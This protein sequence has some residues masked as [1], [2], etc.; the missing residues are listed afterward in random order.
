LERIVVVCV[1]QEDPHC[2][3]AEVG[4]LFLEVGLWK[5]EIDVA[6]RCSPGP[7]VL[8]LV[9]EER[10][11]L[12]LVKVTEGKLQ[13]SEP[14]L[15]YTLPSE[16]VIISTIENVESRAWKDK[17]SPFISDLKTYILWVL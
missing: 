1:F 16:V 10:A 7:E 17:R 2:R 13:G 14:N 4:E 3:V 6:L 8:K 9:L 5:S 12:S 15:L 11:Y